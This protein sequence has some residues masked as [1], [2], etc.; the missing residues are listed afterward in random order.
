MEWDPTIQNK[1]WENSSRKGGCAEIN[2]NSSTIRSPEKS[3]FLRRDNVLVQNQW[4]CLLNVYKVDVS[5]TNLIGTFD[6]S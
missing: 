1:T 4:N 2:K 3:E 6:A 5:S